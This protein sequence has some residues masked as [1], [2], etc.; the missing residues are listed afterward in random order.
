MLLLYSLQYIAC[1]CHN[2]SLLFIFGNLKELQLSLLFCSDFLSDWLLVRRLA[3]TFACTHH[4]DLQP[5]KVSIHKIHSF[6]PPRNYHLYPNTKQ[7]QQVQ[8][9]SGWL[10]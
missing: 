3:F 8:C 6:H 5:D 2:I 4:E 1:N 7:W 9:F 10:S